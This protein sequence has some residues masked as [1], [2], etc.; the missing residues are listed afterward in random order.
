MNVVVLLV[1]LGVAHGA[2][3][4][5]DPD[6]LGVELVVLHRPLQRLTLKLGLAPLAGAAGLDLVHHALECFLVDVH[7]ATRNPAGIAG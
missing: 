2:P 6:G 1:P 4:Q 7:G 5:D 3:L